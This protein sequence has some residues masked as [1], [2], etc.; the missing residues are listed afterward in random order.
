MSA[1]MSMTTRRTRPNAPRRAKYRAARAFYL[2][3][4][5][6]TCFATYALLS[7]TYGPT[8]SQELHI[9]R[10]SLNYDAP[11]HI[12]G[13][14]D[15]GPQASEDDICR[16]VHKAED[17]CAYIHAHCPEDEGGFTAYLDL[18]YCRLT[19]RLQPVAFMILIAWL[20]LLF[21][22][23][24]IAASDFFCIDLNTIAG[25]L[26]MSESMAGVT[27]LAFGNG[28]PDVFS[29]FAAMSTNSGS[30][31]VGELFGAAGFITAV[32]AGS[33]ALIRPFHVAKKSFVRDV[34]FFIVAAAFSM[35]FL[36]D[37]RLHFWECIAMVLYYIFY[38]AFVVAWHWW[39]GR[40]RR[41][42]E[43]DAAARGHFLHPADEL[44][45]ENEP[46]HDDPEDA[47]SPR[48]SFSRGVS[49]E[50]W[51]ALENGAQEPFE[52]A[53]TNEDEEEVARDRW[54]SELASNMRLTRPQQSRSRKNTVSAVRPSLVGALEFQAVL[55]SLH[56]SRNIQTIPMHSRRFSDDPTF[57][58]YQQQDHMASETDPGVRPPY[59]VLVTDE[60]SPMLVRPELEGQSAISAP[61]ARTRAVSANDAATLGVNR[62][63]QRLSPIQTQ[64]DLIE[65][66]SEDSG[67]RSRSQ[68]L[69]GVPSASGQPVSPTVRLEPA[70]PRKD[71]PIQ[72]ERSTS[73]ARRRNQPSDLLAPPG[74]LDSRA[75]RS[76]HSRSSSSDLLVP[77]GLVSPGP[78]QVGDYF[79]S[80]PLSRQGTDESMKDAA[81]PVPRAGRLP[82]I[83]IPDHGRS[84]PSSRGTSPFPAYRDY[85][86]PSMTAS[87]RSPVSYRAP[88]IR[89]PD[90]ETIGSPE[91]IPADQSAEQEVVRRPG[92]L[93]KFWPYRFFPPPGVIISTL[94]PTIYHWAEKTWWEKCLG[95]VAAPSVFCLTITLPVVE[96]ERE[97]SDEM[98]RRDL[99][100]DS[101]RTV[102]SRRDF[103]L[104]SATSAQSIG[105][106]LKGIDSEFFLDDAAHPPSTPGGPTVHHPH[107]VNSGGLA[108]HGNS[109]SVAAATESHRSDWSS[110]MISAEPQTL[111]A[112]DMQAEPQL[113]N[114]WLTIIQLFT[115]PI[116]ILLAIYIQ[117]PDALPPSWLIRPSLICLLISVVL[118]VPLLL[119]TTPFHRPHP[120]RIILSLVGFVVSIAWISAIASQVVGAL[121]ALAVILNMSHAIMG[122]T[123]FAVGNSLGDLV[124]DVTVAKLGYPVM[125]LSACF[126][127]PML[128]ILLGVG[129]SGSW[130][131]LTGA[132]RRQHRHPK[133]GLKFK[134]YHI[135][136]SKTLV[137]SGIT[138]LVTLV[139]LLIAVPLNKWVL[140]KKIGWALIALWTMST[141][142]NVV[143]E[144]TGVLGEA[145]AFMGWA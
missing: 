30:L 108:G 134:S 45:G 105:A 83:Q 66:A 46:Y 118:L 37:G 57:T 119:T 4:F 93:A 87:T 22:T 12:F 73:S 122:L 127:G 130:I 58:T 15:I 2:T 17:K 99:S 32:V 133:K 125:A 23:I 131:M 26:G 38:V 80:K 41:R 1:R 69:L 36:L 74:D 100:Y 141:I 27:F 51:S 40:R 49:R 63:L 13:V 103:S 75:G 68:S 59:E 136:V 35:V 142:F 109:A 120:Y 116:F 132:E 71:A 90:A 92:K 43:K 20:G 123:I 50:D 54:M 139:G 52:D 98:T 135:E 19:G 81:S 6:G 39:L 79:I 29:T 3:C 72:R 60:S 144:V 128:N 112:T 44:E 137:V 18:Y 107:R 124:A 77:P 129:L 21:S 24:G 140:S 14:D 42:R 110:P 84:P 33:M 86:S 9:N 61:A 115:A 97:S 48:P 55:K 82:K 62:K 53:T 89:L 94:F 5:L 16:Q 11:L 47:P 64:G 28:S 67:E 78:H 106:A 85:P 121:K 117:A 126:G 95:I 138:L 76:H 111:Q 7:H 145:E 31:A 65:V 56:K 70:T 34:G 101:A 113:W 143:I 96:S 104:E 91:T 114:R 8:Q 102:P 25:I 88:S 10:R